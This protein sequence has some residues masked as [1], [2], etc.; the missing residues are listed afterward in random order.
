VRQSGLRSVD[1]VH[2]IVD[3]LWDQAQD[4]R[5]DVKSIARDVIPR[6]DRQQAVDNVRSV[7]QHF[8]HM[9]VRRIESVAQLHVCQI[10]EPR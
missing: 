2:E 3:G 9:T 4:V 8:V 7:S 10:Q 1:T 5:R 6:Q